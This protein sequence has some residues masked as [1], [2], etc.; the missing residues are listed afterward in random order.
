LAEVNWTAARPR[1]PNRSTNR[2]QIDLSSPTWRAG[3]DPAQP[4][5][6]HSITPAR[7]LG[8]EL[9]G[10]A[11]AN[12]VSRR[13]PSANE[14]DGVGV[15]EPIVGRERCVRVGAPRSVDDVRIDVPTG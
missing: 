11:G 13:G 15:T 6:T 8:R 7:R 14:L 10:C 3:Q 12:H 2:R 9:L 4:P 1:S 5:A